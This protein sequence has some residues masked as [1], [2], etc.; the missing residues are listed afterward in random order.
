M[1]TRWQE[2]NQSLTT[3]NQARM[4]DQQNTAALK[5]TL[6]RELAQTRQQ[7]DQHQLN[8]L[9]L[10][11]ESL[12]QG[13]LRTTDHLNHG[14]Q[15]LTNSVEF[16]LTDGFLKTT[17][18]FSDVL[19]RLALIDEAQKRMTD[20][21]KDILTLQEILGDKRSRGTFGETQLNALI[22]NVLPT[23]HFSLQHTLSNGKRADCFLFLPPPTGSI[24]IDSKFPLEN[25][26]KLMHAQHSE[27]EKRKLEQQFRID[28]REHIQAVATK[29]IISGET[30]DGAILF[31]PAEA[32]F[33]EIHAHYPDLVEHAHSKRVWLTSPTTLMAI[34]NTTRAVLKD[35][36]TREQVHLIQ[37]HLRALSA[38][39]LRFQQRMD[40]LAR[41]IQQAHTDVQEIKISSDKITNRFCKIEKAQLD[42]LATED[43]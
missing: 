28:V 38:D 41:H 26:K 9:K 11:Q 15:N 31:I 36:A 1:E 35:A 6:I 12:Q 3:L 24:A 29:Y 37:E 4:V 17:E 16:R 27:S 42:K 19:K 18:T 40:H 21:S 39:F 34:L 30:A 8:Q 22:H 33:S 13:L 25:F 2:L 14:I 7:T 10:L 20:L 5:E 23:N 43:L 32:I